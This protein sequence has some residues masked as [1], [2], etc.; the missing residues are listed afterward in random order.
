MWRLVSSCSLRRQNFQQPSAE[1][2][3]EGGVDG[4]SRTVRVGVG[5]PWTRQT[6]NQPGDKLQYER[7]VDSVNLAV[8]VDVA[9]EAIS[10]GRRGRRRSAGSWGVNRR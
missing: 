4:I 2:Q 7:G 6:I 10:A 9:N 1:L 8:A 5:I 3:Y